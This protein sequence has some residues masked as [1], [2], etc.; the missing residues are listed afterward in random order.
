MNAHRIA[1]LLSTLD[2]DYDMD[3]GLSEGGCEEQTVILRSMD[4]RTEV[5]LRLEDEEWEIH[6]TS[7]DC[8]HKVSVVLKGEGFGDDH[9]C[10]L[11][12]M[13]DLIGDF[14][15]NAGV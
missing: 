6:F 9:G 15:T 7:E 14:T 1:Q 5:V 11:T 4:E 8:D 12:D 3:P 13:L 2:A 10:D